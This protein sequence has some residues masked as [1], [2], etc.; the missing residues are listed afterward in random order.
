MYHKLIIAGHLG[1][2]PE[3]RYTPEGTPVTSF[4]MASNIRYRDASG[5]QREETIWFRV[6]V[7]GRQAEIANQYLQKGRPVLVEGRLRP[8]PQTGN[9]RIFRRSDGTAGAVYEV[10]ADR[11]VFIGPRPAEAPSVVEAEEPVLEEPG[12]IEEEE[13]PF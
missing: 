1:T 10:R 3:M 12:S 2:D 13:I 8:D 4:R 7:F 9:P 5:D 6:S 11:I